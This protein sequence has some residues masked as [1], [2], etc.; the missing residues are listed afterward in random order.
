MSDINDNALGDGDRIRYRERKYPRN[1]LYSVDALQCIILILYI[2]QIPMIYAANTNG[3]CG[4][5][6]I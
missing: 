4:I 6:Q 3:I 1:A 5:Y 2:P